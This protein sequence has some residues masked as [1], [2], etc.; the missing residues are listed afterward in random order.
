MTDPSDPYSLRRQTIGIINILI[1]NELS[2]DLFDLLQKCD[3]EAPIEE[4]MIY[5][6]SRAKG[7]F[8]ELGYSKDAIEASLAGMLHDPC[9]QL[10]KVKAL[11]AFRKSESFAK[12]FEVYK[13]AKGQLRVP[14]T[15]PFDPSLAH[16]PAEKKLYLALESLSETWEMTLKARDYPRAFEE[17]AT[18]QPPLAELFDTVKILADDET[19]KNN[20][21]ALLQKVFTLFEELLDFS[22]IQGVSH[23]SN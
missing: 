23:G 3:K 13:R 5:I 20:R 22:K 18:L 2:L 14:A 7:V 10:A 1:E 4:I 11:D 6:T 17:L 8:E 21:I 12:L 15:T 9:D 19:L 16:E